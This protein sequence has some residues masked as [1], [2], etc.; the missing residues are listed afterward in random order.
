[1]EEMQKQVVYLEDGRRA[2]KIVQEEDNV[3]TGETKIV[4]EVWAEPKI[5]KKLTH[6]VVEHR[7]PVIH[8]RE[9]ETVDEET[10]EVVERKVE[11]IEPDVR[12]ELREHI[13]TNS[14]VGALSVDDC[15]CYITQ[16]DMQKTLTEGL[17]AVTRALHDHEVES[18]CPATKVSLQSIIG[19][20][21]EKSSGLDTVGITLCGAIA[22]VAG[23]FVY[24]VFFL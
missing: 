20:K 16:A 24:V 10:G 4:T 23:L 18:T 3:K 14:S 9:I 6:R 13:Q 22:I 7:K 15:D 2:T 21:I 19:E 8:R 1:M 17:L 12:M 5:D 11:S